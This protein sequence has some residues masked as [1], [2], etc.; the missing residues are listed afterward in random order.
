M[1]FECVIDVGEKRPWQD[2]EEIAKKIDVME[3]DRNR[4]VEYR[5]MCMDQFRRALQ[6]L[7]VHLLPLYDN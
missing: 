4:E 3:V 7:K 6:F 5:G 1:K 2:P